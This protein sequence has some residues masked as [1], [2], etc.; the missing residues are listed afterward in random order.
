MAAVERR[1]IP[2]PLESAC[3]TPKPYPDIVHALRTKKVP[4]AFNVSMNEEMKLHI[5]PTQRRRAKISLSSYGL[6][7][8]WALGHLSIKR[9][10]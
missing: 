10:L 8:A 4:E 1:K 3:E 9:T 5:Y 2:L 7:P 6:N